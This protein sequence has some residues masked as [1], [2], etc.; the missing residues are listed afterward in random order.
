MRLCK[1]KIMKAYI[2]F[3]DTLNEKIGSLSSWL[4]AL[5]VLVVNYDVVVRYLIG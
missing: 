5:L 1:M 4:T 3:I 2:K